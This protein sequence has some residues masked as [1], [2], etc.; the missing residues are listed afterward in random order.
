VAFVDSHAHLDDQRFRDD[1]AEVLA[2]ARAAGVDHILAIG[3]GTGADDFQQTLSLTRDSDFV[4]AAL[5]IHPHDASSAK[6]DLLGK[7]EQLVQSPRVV[8]WGEIGLDYHYD[9]SPRDVQQ[10]VFRH[11]LQAARRL[12]FPVIIHC[13]EAWE[14]CL[15]ILEAEWASSG[16]GGILHCFS[17]DSRVARRAAEWGFLVSF[18]GNVTYPRS[19][20]L[21][22]VVRDLPL[23]KVLIETDSPYLAPQAFRGR[24]NEPAYVVAVAETL[25]S[26]HGVTR[27]EIGDQ[28]SQNFL[29]LFQ[30]V[31]A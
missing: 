8:A 17:G 12:S 5:G 31:R 11:Q 22:Q 29:R 13:R 19:D 1:G 30:G 2:R 10:A 6:E 14:D 23:E 20:L 28:T 24:R 7:L 21:R 15:R 18:A 3:N 26:L 4:W 25:A 9:Y 27:A 16:L